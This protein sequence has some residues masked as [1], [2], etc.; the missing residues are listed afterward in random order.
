MINLQKMDKKINREKEVKKDS[1]S[2]ISK[3]SIVI[4]SI[5]I[6]VICIL[7]GIILSQRKTI[8]NLQLKESSSLWI[9]YI[10]KHRSYIN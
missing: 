9:P 3:Q 10:N 6:L 8:N 2:S 1:S 4:K 7:F 5:L